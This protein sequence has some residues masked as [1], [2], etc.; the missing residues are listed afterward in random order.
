MNPLMER[1]ARTWCEA[2]ARA[3]PVQHIRPNG[4]PYLDRYFAA[5][6]SPSSHRRTGERRDPHREN[7]PAIFLHHFVASDPDDQVHSH[8]W[9]WSASLILAGGYREHR[10]T[11]DGSAIVREYR[12][13]DLN[14]L[15]A[16]DLHRVDLLAADCW[17]V[18]L[19]GNFQQAWTFAP[20]CGAR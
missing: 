2:L 18:F 15:E 17:S 7:S 11:A 6:W 20:T 10:C 8:P 12:P 4:Q 19:A 9:G 13:G 16:D 5:G 14:I 3:L 1:A